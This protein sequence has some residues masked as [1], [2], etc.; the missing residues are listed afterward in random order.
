MPSTRGKP[1]NPSDISNIF[2]DET[3]PTCLRFKTR[4]HARQ[5]PELIVGTYANQ[6]RNRGYSF[7]KNGSHYKCHRVIWY[8]C[9]GEDPYGFEID[10]IDG[11]PWNNKIENLRKV[12]R[13]INVRN[14]AKR[15]DNTS[16]ITGVRFNNAGKGRTYWTASWRGLNKEKYSKHFSIENLGNDEAF[17]RAVKCREE[18][19]E[20]IRNIAGYTQRHGI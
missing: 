16:G 10:H 8:L 19:I 3:S 14:A 17:N 5:H 13:E 4:T 7:M 18:A 6:G 2:Y 11:N 12:H 9:H 15:K 1:I 20:A